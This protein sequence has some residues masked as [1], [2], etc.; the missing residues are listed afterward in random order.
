METLFYD[1]GRHTHTKIII[2]SDC[3]CLFR[4]FSFCL[5]NNQNF[6]DQLRIDICDEIAKDLLNNSLSLEEL[7]DY[8]NADLDL[9][10]DF[11]A[12]LHI[13]NLDDIETSNYLVY[14]SQPNRY[15]G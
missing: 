15:G 3:N 14:M 11:L 4:C 2:R 10:R 13:D 5:F 1:N 12:T 9:K 7:K 6:Y 8:I